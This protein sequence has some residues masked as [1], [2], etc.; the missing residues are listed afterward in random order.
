MTKI[1]A[2]RGCTRNCRENTRDAFATALA[3]GV[4]GVEFDVR[5]SRDLVTMVLHDE[6]VDRTSTGSG[7][8]SD[9]TCRQLRRL[10]AGYLSLDEVLDLLGDRLELNV[11]LKPS[12][13]ATETL[14]TRTV[15]TLTDCGRLATA[16]ITAD[17][18]TLLLAR[19]VQPQIRVCCLVPQPRNTAAAID[20][21]LAVGSCTM[22]VG[23]QQIDAAC[24][25]TRCT[26][27]S[28]PTILPRS[29][30]SWRVVSMGCSSTTPRVGS[31]RAARRRRS[32]YPLSPYPCSLA[33]CQSP[34]R[35]QS[36][37]DVTSCPSAPTRG[38]SPSSAPNPGINPSAA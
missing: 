5:L 6:R 23:H 3:C 21:A 34:W 35:S 32:L 36:I 16:Y 38:T 25:S 29:T 30:A 4:D 11:H 18:A 31:L 12:G 20:A 14:V 7:A 17:T 26:W 27:G 19:A 24:R 9:L 2:H 15:R 28:M 33:R 10:D 37:S 8:V 22:Q 1:F 13:P